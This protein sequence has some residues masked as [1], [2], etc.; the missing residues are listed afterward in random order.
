MNEIEVSALLMDH[1]PPVA[2]LREMFSPKQVQNWG[3]GDLNLLVAI[4][5]FPESESKWS[6]DVIQWLFEYG[7]P[8][9]NYAAERLFS[10]DLI[11]KESLPRLRI[12]LKNKITFAPSF[13][14]QL[15]CN[16][17][18]EC[19]WNTRRGMIKLL[20]DYGY[21]VPS[22]PCDQFCDWKQYQ[23]LANSRTAA[24]K[25]VIALLSLRRKCSLVKQCCPRD[26]LLL[27]VRPIWQDERWNMKIWI[28]KEPQKIEDLLVFGEP[29]RTKK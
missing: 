28:K 14:H 20:I 5:L 19:F 18:M 13:I 8:I 9:R 21:T 12:L 25:S 24:L 2:Q 1:R 22:Q 7:Y 10:I 27:I 6:T 17:S 3:K 15:G 26:V 16:R 23:E 11:C 4:H 29:L